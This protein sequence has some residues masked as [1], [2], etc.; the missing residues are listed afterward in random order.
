MARMK[1]N[2]SLEDLPDDIRVE[3][4]DFQKNTLMWNKMFLSGIIVG[5]LIFAGLYFFCIW[6]VSYFVSD[7]NVRVFSTIVICSSFMSA[8]IWA[9]REQFLCAMEYTYLFQTVIYEKVLELKEI[10]RR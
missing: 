3:L 1:K 5:P 6:G 10:E 2:I 8:L 7:P 4:E 9:T